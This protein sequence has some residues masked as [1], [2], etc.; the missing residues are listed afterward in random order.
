MRHRSI[1]LLLLVVSSALAQDSTKAVLADSAEARTGIL[2]GKDHVF[3]LTAPTEWVLDNSS[4]IS[5]GLH[6]VFYRRGGS[7]RKSPTV[8]YAN[9]AHKDTDA[10]QTFGEF[11][12]ADSPRFLKQNPDV[13]ILNAPNIST[14]KGKVAVV[15]K[16]I[17]S[18]YEAVAYV[19]EPKVVV[20]IV[21]T[22]RSQQEFDRSY[23]AFEDLVRSYWFI[24]EDVTFPGKE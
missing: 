22:S 6:A 9:G 5:Q 21:L 1:L 15:R 19:D 24:T 16:F 12:S 8:M 13:H 18:Q 3:C 2:Y 7:W 11:L 23:S 10:K 17:Y 20:L 4:G 14:D